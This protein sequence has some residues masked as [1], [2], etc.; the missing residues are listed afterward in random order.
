MD[1]ENELMVAGGSDRNFEKITYTLLHVKLMTDKHLLYSTWDSAQCYVPALM[2]G[3]FGGEWVHMYAWL[4][5]SA[6][7]L[8]LPQL[9]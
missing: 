8:K 6:V 5:P 1:L 4:S 3:E 7:R 9:C 2:E